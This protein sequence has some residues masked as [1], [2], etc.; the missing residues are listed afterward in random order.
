MLLIVVIMFE[1]H[2]SVKQKTCFTQ[3]SMNDFALMR[4]AIHTVC[5]SG[6]AFHTCMNLK[7]YHVQFLNN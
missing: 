7:L 5:K 2:A 4:Y 6:F 1:V 3:F